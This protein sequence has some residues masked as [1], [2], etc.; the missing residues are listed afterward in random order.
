MKNLFKT[1]CAITL[2][3]TILIPTLTAKATDF[4]LDT[5]TRENLIN[6]FN[7]NGISQEVQDN[8][9][10]K[11]ERGELWDSINPEKQS[12]AISE[13]L[14]DGKVKYTYPDG[15]IV[16][17][18]AYIIVPEENTNLIKPFVASIAS[19][20]KL[21]DSTSNYSHYSSI[22]SEEKMLYKYSYAVEWSTN[23][24]SPSASI[25]SAKLITLTGLAG[26]ISDKEFTRDGNTSVTLSFTYAFLSVGSNYVYSETRVSGR[27]LAIGGNS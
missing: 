4:S 17:K 11:L 12:E 8:L 13:N 10:D 24:Y 20:T 25:M 15:S 7:D 22:I 9:L 26:N 2:S 23:A 18:T 1:L 14:F 3:F 6:E 16:I 21:P 19:T 27:G 5:N